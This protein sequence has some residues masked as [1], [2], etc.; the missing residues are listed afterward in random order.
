[1]GKEQK[2]YGICFDPSQIL[3]QISQSP[4]PNTSAY[5]DYAQYK[6]LSTSP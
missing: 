4:V 1:M 2:N 5:F 3:E 6:S